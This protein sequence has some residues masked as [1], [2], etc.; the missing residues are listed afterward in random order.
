VVSLGVP[1]DGLA[2]LVCALLALTVVTVPGPAASIRLARLGRRPDPAGRT[3]EVPGSVAVVGGATAGLLALG[4]AG[5]LVGGATAVAWFRRRS[6]SRSSGAAAVA[7]TELLDALG[8][9]T[10]ELRAGAHP[11]AALAGAAADG[12]VAR[13]VLA[14]A[15]TAA[16]LGDAVPAA[17]MAEAARHPAVT[18]DL[19]RVARAWALAERHGV[20]PANLLSGVLDDLAWRIGHAGRVRAQLAGP[21]ATAA[22]LTALPALGIAL[23]ELI[24]ADPLAVLRS[25]VLGQLLVILGVGLAAAGAAWTG[26]ILRTAV[27]S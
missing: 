14:P 27:P 10:E 5:A 26:H 19:R 24:G 3:D 7:A 18:D 12:P 22:V 17:L 2:S 6:R 4:P 21:R 11:V 8:R 25:G 23:G 20:P 13:A 9:I 16:A 1:G 15:A